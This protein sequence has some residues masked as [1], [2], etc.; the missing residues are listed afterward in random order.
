MGEK[1]IAVRE[2]LHGLTNEVKD[3][4]QQVVSDVKDEAARQ[5]LT[6]DAAK[7]AVT[8]MVDKVK[9]VAGAARVS[10]SERVKGPNYRSTG[11]A[12]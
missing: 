5:G 7:A 6:K 2:H 8:G 1:R 12:E 4:A 10:V 11:L 3:R 9:T